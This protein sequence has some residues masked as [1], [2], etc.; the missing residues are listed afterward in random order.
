[1][2]KDSRTGTILITLFSLAVLIACASD[3]DPGQPPPVRV[4]PSNEKTD[5]TEHTYKP[6]Q[7]LVKFKKGV[8][9]TE[10]EGIALR[11]GLEMVRVV[12]PPDLYLFRL[13]P[14]I[15][16]DKMRDRLQQLPE[17][18]YAEPNF[19]RKTK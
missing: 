4:G 17:V 2:T 10:R 5:M 15:P 11:A 8:A 12:T 3:P 9:E 19:L 1:V 18:E 13:P 7:I 14:N 6:D 16:P